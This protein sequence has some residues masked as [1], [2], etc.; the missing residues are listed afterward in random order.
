MLTDIVEHHLLRDRRDL[1]Q[2]DLAVETL[3]IKL[4]RVAK[5]SKGLHGMI[6]RI[7]AGVPGEQ[8]GNIGLLTA[9]EIKVPGG[10]DA[11]DLIEILR[12]I[13]LT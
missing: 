6:H 3:N 9:G 5:P 4:A 13:Y 11:S 12:T 8:F 7:T 1:I 10:F 2:A